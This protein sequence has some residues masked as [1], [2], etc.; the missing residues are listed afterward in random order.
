M[1]LSH[2]SHAPRPDSADVLGA[3]AQRH[4][5]TLLPEREK[6]KSPLC[7]EPFVLNLTGKLEDQRSRATC[8]GLLVQASLNYK[9]DE[10]Q[11]S[12]SG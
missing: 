7:F 3:F 6:W 5:V 11:T 4:Y 12:G 10:I 9:E 2:S 8:Q 1:N